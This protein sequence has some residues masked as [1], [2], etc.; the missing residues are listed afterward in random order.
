M[1]N[2]SEYFEKNRYKP[3][4][5]IGDRVRGKWNGIPFIGTVGNDS[6]VSETEGPKISVFLD[7]PIKYEDKIHNVIFIKHK[8]ISKNGKFR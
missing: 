7:L 6:V 5:F 3:T 2:L 8:D 1:M 4:Y